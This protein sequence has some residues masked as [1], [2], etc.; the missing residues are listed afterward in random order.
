MKKVII[1]LFLSI[2]FVSC[3]KRDNPNDNVTPNSNTNTNN[4]GNN[5]QYYTIDATAGAG[6][7]ISPSGQ[8][9]VNLGGSQTYNITAN[10]GYEIDKIMVDG[11]AVGTATY[12]FSNITANH[13]INVTFKPSTTF[14][15]LLKY[16]KYSYVIRDT[17]YTTVP[18]TYILGLYINNIGNCQANNVSIIVTSVYNNFYHSIL[19][20]SNFSIENIPVGETEW[21]TLNF[22][23]NNPH[24]KGEIITFYLTIND[25]TGH[26]W[27]DS[28][29]FTL[30]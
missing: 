8:I 5:S 27:N 24:V 6:G 7:S 28:F 19:A 15:P 22:S 18:D 9:I 11:I 30:D 29:N 2:S 14:T 25:N 3:I 21:G 1:F 23:I 16:S 12:T 13:S 17:G 20:L 4:N 26:T 10:S